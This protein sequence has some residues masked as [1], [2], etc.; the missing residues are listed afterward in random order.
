MRYILIT[1]I[2]ITSVFA[3]DT[4]EYFKESKDNKVFCHM[5]QYSY[6]MLT[7]GEATLVLVNEHWY[8]KIKGKNLYFLSNSCQPLKDSR[9][10]IGF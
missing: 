7:Q 4:M 5:G 9:E 8:F 6:K 3:N 1:F 2:L 10:F